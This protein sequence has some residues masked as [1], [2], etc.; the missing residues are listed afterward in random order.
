V[1]ATGSAFRLT[2]YGIVTL[3]AVFAY[4]YGLDSQHIPKNGDEY[5]YEHITRLTAGSGHLLPLQSQLKGMRNTKPPMLVWQGIASTD[6]GEEWTLWRLRYPSV[7]YTLLTA[8]MV[9]LLAWKLSRELETGFIALLC[10]LAF[11][12][13]Y[14][15]GRPFLTNAPE[16]FWL[17]LPF[18]ALLYWQPI[19]FASRLVA[20]VLLG[21][22]VGVGLLYKSFALVLP[23]AFTLSWWYL[24]RRE[25]RFGV[26]LAQDSWKVAVTATVAL[27]MFGSWFFLDPDPRA[28][29]T[30]F[31]LAENIGKI[32]PHGTNYFLHLIWS[33]DSVG[34]LALG[35]PFNA[36]ALA[37]PVASLF[38][39]AYV[40]RHELEDPEKL[41]W[42][43]VLVL[44]VFFCLPSQRSPR[45]LLAAMPALAILCALNWQRISRKAIV[46]SLLV[47]GAAIALMAYMSLRLEHELADV[48]VYPPIYWI[49]LSSTGALVLLAAFVPALTRLTVNA[50]IVLAYLCLAALLR[51]FDGDLGSYR[52]DIQQYMKGKDVWV[53]CDFRAKDE[54]YRFIFPG[55]GVHG[56]RDDQNRTIPELG[57]KYARF[58]AQLPLNESD[59]TDCKILGERLNVRGRHSRDEIR[60]MLQG[61]VFA[62]LF[63]KELLVEAPEIDPSASLNSPEGCR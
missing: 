2:W 42:I 17:F 14:R 16:V 55:G 62:N 7:V 63:V 59:C 11:F 39:V 49:L 53:P 12:S 8:G 9:F 1:K 3:L 57:S 41:L 51:P 19:G 29:W 23:V 60:Q 18:F 33:T 5:P 15:Y 28:I 54:G 52:V 46:A 50:T 38:A 32:D 48:Q 47:V 45:N 21:V 58:A 40:R 20:P 61:N 27:A 31:V 30:E 13:T 22:G 34:S 56:Y 10:F 43:W 4:F 36:G 6:W 25:Y 26:F 37:F 35:Y 24:H 44:F